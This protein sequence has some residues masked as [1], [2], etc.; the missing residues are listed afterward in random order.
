MNIVGAVDSHVALVDAVKNP[1]A[2]AVE[3]AAHSIDN[4]FSVDIQG[5]AHVK[6]RGRCIA[7]NAVA[8]RCLVRT[9]IILL[10][11][12]AA[13]AQVDRVGHKVVI[14]VGTAEDGEK[15]LLTGPPVVYLTGNIRLLVR[16]T[17]SSLIG[18]GKFQLPF[19]CKDIASGVDGTVIQVVGHTVQI[20]VGA[21]MGRGEVSSIWILFPNGG[22]GT[23]TAVE[24]IRHAIEVGIKRL[25]GGRVVPRIGTARVAAAALGIVVDSGGGTDV[26]LF[27]PDAAGA[28]VE[29]VG[30]AVIVCGKSGRETKTLWLLDATT[31]KRCKKSK[32][33]N[34]NKENSPKSGHPL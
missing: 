7:F 18:L 2:V 30:D 22:V 4:D 24:A 9:G 11:K 28:L 1:V 10:G 5:I 32:K 26:I 19:V 3:R 33:K 23:G 15:L 31:R 29:H 20:E 34:T 25:T 6:S 8:N 27:V 12:G 14:A 17:I 13:V 16:L 21:A